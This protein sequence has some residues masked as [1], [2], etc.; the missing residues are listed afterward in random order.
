MNISKE[1][2]K[3][4]GLSRKELMVLDALREGNTTPA[5]ISRATKVSRP[6]IYE[7]LMRFKDRGIARSTIK[8][9][10]L[11]WALAKEKDLEAELY[12]TKR[13]LLNIKEGIKEVWGVGDSA[14]TVHR[15]APAIRALVQS[16]FKDNKDQ[17]VFGIQGDVV[18]IGWNRIFG[19]EGTNELNRLIKKNMIIIEG[20]I[21]AGWF[22]RQIGLFGKKWAEEFVGRAA[23]THEIDGRYFKHGGQIFMFQNS[24][25]LM[26]MNEEIVIEVRNSEI[27][28]MILSLM[29]F[30]QENSKKIDVNSIVRNLVEKK[31]DTP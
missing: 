11:Q 10:K 8:N 13:Q 12:A 4:L 31:I 2:I 28:K 26:A 18:D 16:M 9:G 5:L 24:L 3:L 15:G 21:P 7:I 25:Y 6:A 30:I 27:Q 23:I 14:V 29:L 17:K 1:D 20:I 19:V 22:E